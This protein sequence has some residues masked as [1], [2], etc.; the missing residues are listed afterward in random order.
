MLCRRDGRLWG[1]PFFSQ[2][3]LVTRFPRKKHQVEGRGRSPD[4][5]GV[6]HERDSSWSRGRPWGSLI[7]WHLLV[8]CTGRAPHAWG[9]PLQGS[10]R[11][12][13]HGLWADLEGCREEGTGVGTGLEEAGPE[14]GSQEPRGRGRG[15]VFLSRQ[16]AESVLSVTRREGLGTPLTGR[17]CQ[18]C[19]PGSLGGRHIGHSGHL[20]GVSAF[21]HPSEITAEVCTN[22]LTRE[23]S[24]PH[25]RE[26][27]YLQA[28]PS[29]E[30]RAA[31][32]VRGPGPHACSTVLA[33]SFEAY[34]ASTY[35]LREKH[36]LSARPGS[37]RR[38]ESGTAHV[39]VGLSRK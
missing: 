29:R 17:G 20:G 25:A 28:A 15:S 5:A 22:A 13:G 4:G 23:Q 14:P 35:N 33:H 36:I 1:L 16:G 11:A 21:F 31:A 2:T 8:R 27:G 9:G 39:T 34:L 12:A 10:F 37:Q 26:A 3:S 6:G 7:L 19:G 30:M 38:A 32:R 24:V 18:P